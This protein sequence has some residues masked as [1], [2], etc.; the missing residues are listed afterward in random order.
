MLFGFELRDQCP[1]AMSSGGRHNLDGP[2]N[3]VAS[4]Q[5]LRHTNRPDPDCSPTDCGAAPTLQQPSA[6]HLLAFSGD[7]C[8]PRS[9]MID[10]LVHRGGRHSITQHIVQH[11][12]RTRL[13]AL[14]S[15]QHVKVYVR[16]PRSRHLIR[17]R[18]ERTAVKVCCVDE[19]RILYS[20]SSIVYC[21]AMSR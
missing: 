12:V 11:S 4:L 18:S 10:A 5:L 16:G 15:D 9:D 7:F 2:S 1:R 8:Q 6:A 17:T 21:H 3:E 14:T 20:I 19:P 13:S